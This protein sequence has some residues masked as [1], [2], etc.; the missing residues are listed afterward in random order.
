MKTCLWLAV[1]LWVVFP[2]CAPVNYRE[3]RDNPYEHA[4]AVHESRFPLCSAAHAVK[5]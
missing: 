4:D 1:A 3:T 2:G 5:D